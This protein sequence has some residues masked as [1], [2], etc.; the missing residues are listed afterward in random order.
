MSEWCPCLGHTVPVGVMTTE[1]EKCED[2]RI[3]ILGD[4]NQPNFANL[5]KFFHVTR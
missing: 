2:Y 1:D 3:L 5:V 4:Y